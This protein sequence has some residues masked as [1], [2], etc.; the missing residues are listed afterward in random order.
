M[1]REQAVIAKAARLLEAS[2]TANAQ[3]RTGDVYSLEFDDQAFDVA[4][5][6][7]VLQHLTDPVAALVEMRRM[8]RPGGIL[9]VCDSDYGGFIWAP[10]D[11]LLDWWLEVYHQ[12]CG[13]NRADADAGTHL[14]GWAQV[15]GF[16]DIRAGSS[17][18]RFADV[19]SRAVE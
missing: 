4:H 17:T 5:A 13:R 18:W 10:S 7:Q 19:L 6:H 3:F 16:G 11:P 14:F 15:A 8:L 12:V 2:A 9:A 1:D